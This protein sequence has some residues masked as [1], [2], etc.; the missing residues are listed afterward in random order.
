MRGIEVLKRNG[1][2]RSNFYVLAGF[3]SSTFDDALYRVNT[4]KELG[5][6]AYVMPY[7]KEKLFKD[8][9]RY[10]QLYR[11]TNARMLFSTQTYEEYCKIREDGTYKQMAGKRK[12]RLEAKKNPP[13]VLHGVEL[14]YFHAAQD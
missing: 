8:D 7:D 3:Q 11:W 6:R 1:I 13:P 2:N 10:S 12:Q 14:T 5:Q 9:N 4:L